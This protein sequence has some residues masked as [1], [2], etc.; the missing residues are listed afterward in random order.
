MSKAL[1]LT[2]MELAPIMKKSAA[3]CSFLL[4]GL[5]FAFLIQC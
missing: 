2:T 4:M 1:D 3:F 5:L